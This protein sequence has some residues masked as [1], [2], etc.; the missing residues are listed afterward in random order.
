VET[1]C[2]RERTAVHLPQ[3]YRAA[4]T[5]RTKKRGWVDNP[6]DAVEVEGTL[7]RQALNHRSWQPT[8]RS[9]EAGTAAPARAGL[10][11]EQ[12]ADLPAY[13]GLTIV[14]L[15]STH[16]GMPIMRRY[17]RDRLQAAVK[18]QWVQKERHRNDD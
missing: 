6:L 3:N 9:A 7:R 1:G 10:L 18:N 11:S 8:L 17:T 5:I 13:L 12:W 16:N 2:A 14:R 15:L 4:E